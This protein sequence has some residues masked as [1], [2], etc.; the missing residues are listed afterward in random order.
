VQH[1]LL[2]MQCDRRRNDTD[3]LRCVYSRVKYIIARQVNASFMEK[4][5]FHFDI[6]CDNDDYVIVCKIQRLNNFDT[7]RKSI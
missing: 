7:W 2:R 3:L 6:T 5:T 1:K 4:K